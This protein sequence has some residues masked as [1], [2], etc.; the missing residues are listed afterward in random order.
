MSV[1]DN[2]LIAPTAT[3]GTQPLHEGINDP[4]RGETVITP[5]DAGRCVLG[6]DGKL[7][8]PLGSDGLERTKEL[9][10]DGAI[11]IGADVSDN[12]GEEILSASEWG[13]ITSIR[14]TGGANSAIPGLKNAAAAAAA[15]NIFWIGSSIAASGTSANPLTSLIMKGPVW[16]YRSSG[17]G[18]LKFQ[19]QLW[20]RV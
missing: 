18:T 1:E 19:R 11:E 5:K 8:T 16:G 9:L 20:A 2:T 7:H 15:G 12:T 3:R 14:E 17:T 6:S 13:V 4:L 10:P